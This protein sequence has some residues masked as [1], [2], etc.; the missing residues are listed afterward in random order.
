[1]LDDLLL[2]IDADDGR[3]YVN[4]K[5]GRQV[6][7]CVCSES[8]EEPAGYYCMITGKPVSE[9][10]A[11]GNISWFPPGAD[12]AKIALSKYDELVPWLAI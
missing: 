3:E 10:C 6:N 1:M 7:P 5:I 4:A 9:E 2:E 11:Q 8:G 12:L